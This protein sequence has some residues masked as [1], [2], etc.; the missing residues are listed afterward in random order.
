MNGC[1]FVWSEAQLLTTVSSRGARED[2]RICHSGG[3]KGMIFTDS[4][5]LGEGLR[6]PGLGRSA[7]PEVSPAPRHGGRPWGLLH[8]QEHVRRGG[9][10][11]E[12]P[13]RR[14]TAPGEAG[15][16]PAAGWER[17]SLAAFISAGWG[18]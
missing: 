12:V 8:P 18:T 14:G 5:M 1:A 9:R 16:R 15:A 11:P 13:A 2:E 3:K 6:L 17:R 7:E 10:C 4:P